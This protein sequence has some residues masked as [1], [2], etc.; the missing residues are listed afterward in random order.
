MVGR[1]RRKAFVML[2]RTEED[3]V[4]PNELGK[5]TV[6][7]TVDAVTYRTESLISDDS[8]AMNAFEILSASIVQHA[9]AILNA[10]LIE[11][12][13]ELREMLFCVILGVA[14]IDREHCPHQVDERVG[15]V[16]LRRQERGALNCRG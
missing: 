3:V 14:F 12:V 6:V 16:S 4:Q 11:T 10:P 2:T 13:L 5:S 1:S 7:E 8:E 9:N 15:E